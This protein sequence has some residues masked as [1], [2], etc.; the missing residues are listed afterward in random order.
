ML[1]SQKNFV[2]KIH[3]MKT[4]M[5]L[6]KPASSQSMNLQLLKLTPRV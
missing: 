1:R 5:T 3:L 2:T 4:K 6:D